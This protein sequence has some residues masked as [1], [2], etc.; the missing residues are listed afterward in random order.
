MHAIQISAC[1]HCYLQKF[2]N[3]ARWESEMKRQPSMADPLFIDNDCLDIYKRPELHYVKVC[4]MHVG[5]VSEEIL[6]T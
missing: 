4:S 6:I 1:Q 2:Y 5:K 3:C